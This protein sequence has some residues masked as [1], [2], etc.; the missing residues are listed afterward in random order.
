MYF[1][2]S[3][4]IKK[5]HIWIAAITPNYKSKSLDV[6]HEN[7]IYFII[8]TLCILK[9]VLLMSNCIYNARAS[10]YTQCNHWSAT[11]ASICGSF[12]FH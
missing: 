2:C 10:W 3:V 4:T 7:L 12:H 9:I 11:S 5:Q 6:L 8:H 1:A